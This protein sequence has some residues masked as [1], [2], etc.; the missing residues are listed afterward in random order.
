MESIFPAWVMP[1]LGS[2]LL[3]GVYD[4]CKKAAVKENSVMPVLFYATLCGTLFFCAVT[5]LS[6]QLEEAVFCPLPAAAMLFAKALLVGASWV[7]V[8]Y[9]MRELPISIAAPIR[10]TAPLWTFAGSLIL[11]HEFPSFQQAAAML[12]IFAGY[13][14][15]SVLGK[16]EDG[17][18]LHS[19]GLWLI[20]AGT[21]LG[22]ASALYDKFLLGVANIPRL[23]VQFHFSVDLIIILGA[24]YFIRANFF[25][26]KHKFYWRWSIFF[27]GILLI[28]ADYLYFYALSVPEVRI[29]ILSLVRRC[30]CIVSFG[31]G[32][33]YFREVNIWKKAVALIFILA[34]VAWL[35][36]AG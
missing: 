6:G 8:Y 10:A 11:Y 2:A 25:G 35:L 33:Y 32:C 27:T 7:C 36:L 3:L 5:A 15:F 31:I 13:Y 18:F 14:A 28:L 12:L 20:V 9:A 16:K 4:V 1:I 17:N 23:T 24:A 29:S 30:N 34:G 22:A 19:R 21:L 26:Q